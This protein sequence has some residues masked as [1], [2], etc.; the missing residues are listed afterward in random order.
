[1]SDIKILSFNVNGLGLE[2]K[3]K[4]LFTKLQKLQSIVLLQETHSTKTIETKWKI[5]WKSDIFYAHGTSNSRGVAIL[6]PCNTEYKVHNI[7][8]DEQDGRFIIMDIEIYKTRILVA[9][10][11]MPTRDHELEQMALLKCFQNNLPECESLIIGGDFNLYLN[12]FLDKHPDMKNT[13][14]NKSF[15]QDLNSFIETNELSDVW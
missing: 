5:E 4:A 8:R 6:L 13:N 1:M 3:R 10:I 2:R 7:I 11:Y 9:N 15:R 14:D 12:P